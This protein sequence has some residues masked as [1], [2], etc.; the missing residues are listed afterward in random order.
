MSTKNI[1]PTAIISTSAIIG[2]NV[3]IGPYCI[4]GEHVKLGD[5]TELKAHVVIEGR[6]TIGSGNIIYP[7]ASIGNPPQDLKYKG[8]PSEVIIGNNNTIREYVTIQPGTAAGGMQT[9]VGNN[10]LLMVGVHIAHDCRV[11]NRIVLANYVSLAGHVT[12]HDFVIL[13]GLSAVQQ[14]T[15]I[16]QYAMIGGLSG[17]EKDIIPFG[18]AIG[19]RAYLEGVNLVGLNRHGFDKQ[20]S[21]EAGKVIEE[22]FNGNEGVF[23]RRVEKARMQYKH[24]KIIMQIIDFLQ[25]DKTRTFCRFKSVAQ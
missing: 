20:D 5:N 23:D 24:N 10:N 3:R 21:L 17:V 12:L 13:G 2:N 25:A 22:I 11:G 15:R 7:F 8:E 1:H 16:G 9:I 18:L 19:N 4:V 14:H 6:T